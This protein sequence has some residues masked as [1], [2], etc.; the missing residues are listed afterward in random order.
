MTQSAPLLPS[1]LAENRTTGL[2][3]ASVYCSAIPRTAFRIG[4]LAKLLSFFAGAVLFNIEASHASGESCCSECVIVTVDLDSEEPGFQTIITVDAGTRWLRDVGVWIYAPGGPVPIHSIGYIGGLNRGLA[5]GHTPFEAEHSGQ[6]IAITAT[7]LEPLVDG[8]TVFV[9]SGFDKLFEGAE[10]QYFE[11]GAFGAEPGT[12]GVDPTAPVLTVDIE[13]AN[14]TAGDR[15]HFYL[16]DKTAEWQAGASGA[17]SSGDVN[18]LES[19]GDACP[20]ET[21]TLAGLDSDAAVPLPPALFPVDYIDSHSGSGGAI[22]RVLNE[23][24]TLRGS[25]L[26]TLLFSLTAS[27]ALVLHRRRRGF[28]RHEQCRSSRLDARSQ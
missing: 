21:N 7:H 9:N 5:L 6:V 14:A 26:V 11:T 1:D 25:L 18:S 27:T 20:D 4:R 12:I 13:F 24:P 2:N 17:F 16:G 28:A 8:N 15:F 22:V 19:G 3:L 10:V 23:V